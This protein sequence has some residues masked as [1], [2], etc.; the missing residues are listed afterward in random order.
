MENKMIIGNREFDVKH[1][2]YIMGILN[3]T[4]DSFS[5]GGIYNHIDKALFRVEKMLDEGMDI[6]DIGGESTRPGYEKI[7]EQEEIERILPVIEAVKKNFDLPVSLDTYKSKVALEGI[8]AGA[9]MINDIWGLLYDEEMAK[10]IAENEVACCLMHNRKEAVYNNFFKE[11]I[12]DLQYILKIAH[13]AGINDNRI[14]LDPG[15]GFGKNYEQNLEVIRRVSELK[16]LG[17]PILLGTS[18]KS[19]IGLALE[20]P[21]ENRLNG[22]LA[23]SV[24][25]V[26]HGC[27]FLRVHDIK[28]NREVVKMTEAIMYSNK[29]N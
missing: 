12:S 2:T 7:K 23:T 29:M 4:P 28:E 21:V 9:D 22:T 19:V 15:V 17:Y 6:L 25:G 24:Y 3:V 10:V 13:D 8:K 11:V 26:M 1:H 14:M 16:N 18:R 5:D 20:L 27:S